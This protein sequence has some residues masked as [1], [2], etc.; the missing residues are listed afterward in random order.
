MPSKTDRRR[1]IKLAALSGAGLSL[2]NSF[3]FTQAASLTHAASPAPQAKAPAGNNFIPRRAAS[4][5]C[6]LDDLLWPQK[7]VIDKIKRRAD[8][9]AKAQIDTAI[10]FGFHNRFDFSNY[11]DR[12]HGYYANVCQELHQ[13][14]IRFM[15]HYSCNHICRPRD[16]GDFRYIN[17][18]ERH[19]V[20][21]FPDPTAAKFAQYEGHLFQ[22]LCEVDLRDGSRGYAKQ[23]QF[24]AFCHNNPG[25]HDMHQ[26]YLEKLMKEVPFDG[27]E[28]DDMCTYPGNT[29]CGCKYC[30]DRFRK[31][32]GH[33]IPDFSNK[34]F[35][36]DTTKEMLDWGNYANPAYRDWLRMKSD[37][38]RDHIMMIKKTVGDKPLM[39]CCSNTGPIVLS[40]VALDLE[41]MAPYLDLF[42]LENVGTNVKNVEWV[43][44]DAEALLQKDIAEKRGQAPAMALSY[45]LSEKGAY[46]G[47]ALARFWGVGNWSS[48]LNGRLEEDPPHAMEMEDVISPS[49]NWEK[50][51]SDLDYM[52]GRDIPEVRVVFSS[53]CKENGWRDAAGHEHWD[54]VKAWSTQLV[55]H[56]TGY[57]FVRAAELADP[58]ALAKEKTPLIL[59]GIGCVSDKQ[60]AAIKT[61]LAAGNTA[62]LALPFGT[63]DEKGF[64]RKQPLSQELLQTKNKNLHL[65]DSAVSSQPLEKLI[66]AKKFTPVIQQLKGDPRWAAR[67][68]LYDDKPVIHF[69]NTGLVALPDDIKDLSGIPMMK[70][71]DSLVTDNACIYEVNTTHLNL[72]ELTLQS[73]ELNNI[74]RPV[75]IDRSKKASVTLH[76]DLDQVKIY[77]VAQTPV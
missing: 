31:D 2:A 15:D 41:K 40:A 56:N 69:M 61:Y 32:Y 21:L 16:E 27:I 19:A 14:N 44:M 29:T 65:I 25:H 59:D 3:T 49:N 48:T 43:E 55:K 24:E 75:R 10:N 63:H 46:L 5:W 11:F 57:R 42:M 54:R 58:A 35:F 12:L 34:S 72:N 37:S 77:A 30:R 71:I 33:E 67:I 38:V 22:D 47:W 8:G 53:Y 50:Q 62:W 64:P 60:F 9:F 20:L 17:K 39:T 36:G 45:E 70:D 18:Y 52:Q 4:W 13:R 28:V 1:F 26:K 74:K 6:S 66:A 68:R 76:V 7:P 73:P 23:Y 51:Y